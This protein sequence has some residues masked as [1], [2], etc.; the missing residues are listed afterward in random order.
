MTNDW[1]EKVEHNI[2][3]LANLI[4][5]KILLWHEVD[6]NI[7]MYYKTDKKYIFAFDAEF[8]NVIIK[9]TKGFKAE[10]GYYNF[11]FIRAINELGGMLFYKYY[12]KWYWI[13]AFY[14]NLP[15][16]SDNIDDIFLL[17][18][19][20]SDVS[21]KNKSKL[22]KL[23]NKLFVYNV[24]DDLIKT[25][26]MKE[27]TEEEKNK[28]TKLLISNKLIKKFF[29]KGRIKKL[30]NKDI[31]KKRFIKYLKSIQ[32]NIHG[33]LLKKMH[34]HKEYNIY[35]SIMKLIIYDKQVRLR[36]IKKVKKFLNCISI[37]FNDSLLIIKGDLDIIA[38]KN[39][40]KYY[41]LELKNKYK[42]YDIA[43]HNEEFHKLCNSAELKEDYDCLVRFN[44]DN[45]VEKYKYY[46]DKL[47]EFIHYKAHNPLVDGYLTWVIFN[48]VINKKLNIFSK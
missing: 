34:L 3:K 7:S 1:Y 36:T 22:L 24:L 16:L 30:L 6:I 39:H 2:K 33:K 11:S 27:L 12:N 35:R 20:Y 5:N 41:G 13:M 32:F 46:L 44:K 8:Q 37:L 38:F 23:E 31:T 48:T 9:K 25:E 28:I 29:S 15:F 4:P 43:L 47:S 26:T 21:K 42:T 18:S 19:E 17:H 14:I 45:F 10:K 40:A